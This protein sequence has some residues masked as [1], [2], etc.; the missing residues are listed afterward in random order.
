MN[1]AK[2]LAVLLFGICLAGAVFGEQMSKSVPKGWGENFA[3]AKE[4]ASQNGKLLLIAFSGSD[5]CGWCMKMEKEIYSDHKFIHGAKKNFVL[6][7]VDNPRDKGILSKLAQTQNPGIIAEYRVSGY[8]CTVIARPSGE[9]IRRIGGYQ[10]GGVKAFLKTL[11]DIAT[12][13]GLSADA[14]EDPVDENDRDDRFFKK[15]DEKARIAAREERQRKANTTNEFELTEFA[16]IQF[17]AGRSEGAP[18][19]AEPYL[20]LTT[21]QNTRYVNGKLASATFAAPVKEVNAMSAD[22]LRKAT[23]RLV[24]AI[25]KDLGIR[26]AVTDSSIDFSGRNTRITVFSSKISGQLAV[27]LEKKR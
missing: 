8:P 19:L 15:P 14:K 26:F 13:A 1:Q 10:S 23:C 25:E 9:E 16:G 5:W 11:G 7:M 24:Q 17:G 2:S 20:M 21:V 4:E 27:R 12:E 22:E 3:A 6:V 18:K